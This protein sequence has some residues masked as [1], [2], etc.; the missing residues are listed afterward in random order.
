[1]LPFGQRSQTCFVGAQHQTTLG[2]QEFCFEMLLSVSVATKDFPTCPNSSLNFLRPCQNG[3]RATVARA[4]GISHGFED[5][6]IAATGK[7]CD[8]VVLTQNEKD[9][10][11]LGVRYQKPFAGLPD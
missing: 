4:A 9:F 11:P 1:M 6:A 7:Q 3:Y 2:G 5:I 8:L 10:Q